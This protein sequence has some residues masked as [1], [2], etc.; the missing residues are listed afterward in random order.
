MAL[1]DRLRAAHKAATNADASYARLVAWLEEEAQRFDRRVFT[2]FRT[3]TNQFEPELYF[4]LDAGWLDNALY[5]GVWQHWDEIKV[6]AKADGIEAKKAEQECS[7]SL[8]TFFFVLP[9]N[10][11]TAAQQ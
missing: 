5:Q 1:A 9:L 3:T 4:H 6:R 8:P 11:P 7:L 2:T 10:A